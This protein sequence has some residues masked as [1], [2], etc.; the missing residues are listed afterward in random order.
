MKDSKDY[1]RDELLEM[2]WHLSEHHKLTLSF[3]REHDTTREYEKSLY[4]FASSGTLNFDGEN[5]IFT[6]KGKAE[7]E[8]IIRRHRLAE[9]LMSNV[10]GIKPSETEEAACEFE[11]ILSP[12]LVDSICTLLGH[13]PKCPHG[14]TI[15]QGK[16]CIEAKSSVKSA[17]IPIT[18]MKIGRTAKIA[19]L[20][21]QSD[22]RTHKLLTMGL[23]PGSEIR[24]HQTKPVLVVEVDNRQIALENSIGD[25]INVWKP[26]E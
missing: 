8:G 24:L 9:C 6:E 2:L 3:L 5:I 1:R 23:N 13:P 12:E 20:N 7:A 18:K 25:E 21:T 4:E 14:E 10:L 26:V 11:H 19:F 16:C 17:V 22:R 15:P